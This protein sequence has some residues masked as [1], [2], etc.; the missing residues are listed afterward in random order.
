MLEYEKKPLP[1]GQFDETEMNTTPYIST[2]QFVKHIP[3][4]HKFIF[5]RDGIHT[6]KPTQNT[7]R[8]FTEFFTILVVYL[9]LQDLRWKLSILS[10]GNTSK[11]VARNNLSQAAVLLILK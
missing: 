3:V 9:K 11:I 6:S 5:D 10:P 7:N 2:V 1:L 8:N 4:K